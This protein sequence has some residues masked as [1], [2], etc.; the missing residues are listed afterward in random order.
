[1]RTK[2]LKSLFAIS[3]ILLCMFFLSCKESES[4]QIENSQILDNSYVFTNENGEV[5]FITLNSDKTGTWSS[6]KDI[7]TK[8]YFTWAKKG[9][10]LKAF[11]R[12]FLD[13]IFTLSKNE[14]TFRASKFTGLSGTFIA[15]N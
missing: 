13:E 4:A 12:D 15:K 8:S 14:M 10:K 6:S 11:D 7:Q 2:I 9:S 3:S 5:I 1:M